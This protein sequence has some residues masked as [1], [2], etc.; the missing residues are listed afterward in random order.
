MTTARSKPRQLDLMAGLESAQ[1]NLAEGQLRKAQKQITDLEQALRTMAQK[2]KTL[3]AENYMLNV[4]LS[5]AQAGTSQTGKAELVREL[6]KLAHPDKWSQGQLATA[7][8]HEI[9]VRLT[10]GKKPRR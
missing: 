5:Q 1:D 3:E 6:I 2:T 4:Y 10:A 8:A 9:T 7:L